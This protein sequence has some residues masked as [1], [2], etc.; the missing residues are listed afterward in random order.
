MKMK[1]LKW[2][3][4]FIAILSVVML[5]NACSTPKTVTTTNTATVT[6]SQTT[7]TVTTTTSPTT[8]SLTTVS[9]TATINV[10]NNAFQP[11]MMTARVGTT[12]NFYNMM[13]PLTLVGT[14]GFTM[15]SF[16]GMMMQTGGG[17]QYTFNSPGTYV[18]SASG[19]SFICTITVVS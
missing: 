19:Q 18:V 15:G 8:T 3:I 5:T 9:G 1:N 14:S 17:Y 11:P 2:P 4:L 12:I 6:A 16:G 10:A 7:T 13:G